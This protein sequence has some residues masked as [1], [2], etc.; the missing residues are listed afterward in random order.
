MCV[1]YISVL[2]FYCSTRNYAKWRSCERTLRSFL[3]VL[4]CKRIHLFMFNYPSD[5]MVCVWVYNKQ[6][7]KKRFDKLFMFDLNNFAYWLVAPRDFLFHIIFFSSISSIK[8]SLILMM[9]F[10]SIF[11]GVCVYIC[12]MVF[13]S[14]KI[15]FS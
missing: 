15:H 3:C 12:L 7:I 13:F 1:K 4:F 9:R 10:V 14:W 11:M 6:K 8:Y 5:K 2:F